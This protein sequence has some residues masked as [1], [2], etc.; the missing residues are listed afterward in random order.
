MARPR[1]AS[2]RR[3]V[4]ALIVLTAV[5]L[6][7]LDNRSGRSGPIGAAG[8]LAH[9]IVSPVQRA[10][11]A[12]ASPIG[13]W[14][15]GMID[16][17]RLKRENRR[18]RASVARLRGEQADARFAKLEYEKLKALLD[19]KLSPNAHPITARVLDRDPGNFEST[20]TIDRGQEVGIEKDMAVV[21]GNGVV[22]HVIDSWR[23]GAKVRLLTDSAS[24]IAVRTTKHP[25][26]GIAQGRKGSDELVIGDFEADA[27][28]SKGD[29][30]VTSDI[31]NSVFP[32]DLA[33]GVV[34][35]VDEQP[36]GLGLVVRVKPSVDFN[37]LEFVR[38]LRW[39]PGQGAVVVPTTTT[40]TT[41][42]SPSGSSTTSSSTTTTT[43]TPPTGGT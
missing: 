11:S 21:A 32:P 16:S 20:L 4:L 43:L 29:D 31:A 26:T 12:V 25:V 22:G 6:I 17:G 27:H 15:S 36:A 7:T 14:W 33:V 19:L 34:T 24:A 39:V 42:T 37:A 38:V 40:T 2:R 9:T 28:V 18:L 23:G 35:S 1:G 41:T 5:T 10:T 30:L 13:D 8:R 3:F